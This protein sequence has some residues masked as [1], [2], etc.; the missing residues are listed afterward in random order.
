MLLNLV[1]IIL[2]FILLS[3]G[4]LF[5][6]FYNRRF[7]ESLPLTTGVIIGFLYIFYILNILHIG[8]YILLFIIA[9]LILISGYKFIRSEDKKEVLSYFF[10]PG[11]FIFGFCFLVVLV[12]VYQ[13]KVLLWDELRLWGAYP[14]LLYYDGSLQLGEAAKLI[15]VMQSY[16]PGMPIFQ[17]FFTKSALSFKEGYLFL[18]YAILGMSILL[19]I[20]KKLTWKHWYY[21]PLFALILVVLPIAIGNSGAIGNGFDS[22]TYYYTLYIE[23]ILGLYFGFTLYLSTRKNDNI[24]DYLTFIFSI[25]T[26]VL[27]K[28]TGIIFATIS[29][30]S[31]LFIQKKN[32]RKLNRRRVIRLIIPIVTCLL[33]FISWK[34]VQKLYLSSNMYASTVK[35]EEIIGFFTNMSKEQKQILK[36][37]NKSA[38]LTSFDSNFDFLERFAGFYYIFIAIIIC[39]ILIIFLKTKKEKYR[40][41]VATICYIGGSIFF[42]LGLLALYLFSLHVVVCFQ[43]YSSV[44]LTAGLI[45]IIMVVIDGL[46][47]KEKYFNVIAIYLA[48]FFILFTPMKSPCLN[49]E[50]VLMQAAVESEEYTEVIDENVN[51]KKDDILLVFGSSTVPDLGSVIYQ[52]H[53]YMNL[54]DEGFIFLQSAV[55]SSEDSNAGLF[56]ATDTDK[57]MDTIDDYDYVYF[58]I[59]N[60]EDKEEF[61]SILD[62]EIDNSTLYRVKNNKLEVVA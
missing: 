44:V 47:D 43:R 8:Y 14:K 54:I 51:P 58:I 35:S 49:I 60:D 57:V 23:P 13:R 20:T 40:Y 18:A 61:A 32:Y 29:Y 52:H 24:Y 16:Q 46:F 6:A 59:V 37:F 42:E 11:F 62:T 28:D 36:D 7:E 41:I 25:A 12:L 5:L 50:G 55:L 31:F 27:L 10:T 9:C 4:S 34:G 15:P 48:L 53:I 30:L 21:F 26:L 38:K 3:S 56:N 2:V 22:L 1:C 19:P 17:F 33:I 39:L 45:F